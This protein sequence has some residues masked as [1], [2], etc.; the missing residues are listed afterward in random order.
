MTETTMAGTAMTGNEMTRT[1]GAVT[2]GVRL[3]LR[4]EGLGLLILALLLYS[5]TDLP[6][7]TFAVLFL[8]PDLG[9]LGYLAGPRVGAATYNLMHHKF[10]PMLL[11]IISHFF[12]T[13]GIVY[14][15]GLIWLAHIGMDHAVGYGLKYSTGFA[16]THLGRIGKGATQGQHS[17]L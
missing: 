4:L 15:I 17:S 10:G 3:L 9:L 5:N 1:A 2:G 16:F 8:V 14:A 12:T 11:I 6:W 13:H 7:L